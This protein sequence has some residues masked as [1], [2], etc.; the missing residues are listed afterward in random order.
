MGR[1]SPSRM[2]EQLFI[3]TARLGEVVSSINGIE[4]AKLRILLQRVVDCLHQK[5]VHGFTDSEETQLLE[6]LG[7]DEEALKTVMEGS[8]FFFERAAY[9]AIPG[10]VLTEQLQL[11]KMAAEQAGAF[12][13]IWQVSGA[14]AV[15][16]LR[17]RPLGGTKV[18]S[19][20]N[21]DLQMRVADS[22]HAMGLTPMGV[23]HL[24]LTDSDGNADNDE[25][26]MMELPH[27]KL[28][29]LFHNLES[30]QEQL[31]ALQ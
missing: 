21:W 29:Q 26:L 13:E 22:A 10:D 3:E 28:S 30:I 23:L 31:D 14:T 7:L 1:E 15:G 11:V 19:K 8:A 25:K 9:D 6:V 16:H 18:L 4:S 12:G 2:A 20:V 5:N 27:E 24:S 17:D